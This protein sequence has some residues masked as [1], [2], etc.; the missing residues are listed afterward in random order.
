MRASTVTILTTLLISTACVGGPGSPPN[1]ND[2]SAGEI[3]TGGPG[4]GE[5]PGRGDDDDD[6]D[7][8]PPPTS[9][10]SSSG[11]ET[12]CVSEQCTPLQCTCSGTQVPIRACIENRCATSCREVGCE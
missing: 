2:D 9:P 8:V 4:S 11:G 1:P 7:Y 5:R 10:G 6:D 3:G 12:G